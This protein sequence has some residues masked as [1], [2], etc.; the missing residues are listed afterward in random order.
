MTTNKYLPQYLIKACKQH[1]EYGRLITYKNISEGVGPAL[2][3][4]ANGQEFDFVFSQSPFNDEA[5]IALIVDKESAQEALSSH[6]LMPATT[7]FSKSESLH[8]ITALV[9]SMIASGEMEYPI[10]VKPNK[11]SLSK[12]VFIVR[13]DAELQECVT[14][15]SE[16]SHSSG[17]ILVQ[18]YIPSDTE[19]RVMFFEGEVIGIINKNLA[20]IE[21]TRVGP[22]VEDEWGKVFLIHDE[23]LKDR[24]TEITRFLTEQHGLVYGGLDVRIDARN[25]DLYLLE[26]NPAPMGYEILEFKLE[27][28]QEIIDKI[29]SKMLDKIVRDSQPALKSTPNVMA[30]MNLG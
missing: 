5:A 1:P 30:A 29:T 28:G 19:L 13:D 14:R 16:I 11:E 6:I 15:C 8:D 26:A 25:G 23:E 27:G 18:E 17:S 7:I 12:G 10:V 21:N 24:L 9:Q 3:I 4:R 2:S 20:N 22:G